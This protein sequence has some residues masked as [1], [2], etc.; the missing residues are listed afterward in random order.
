[1]TNDVNKIIRELQAIAADIEKGGD[2]VQFDVYG[3]CIAA[4]AVLKAQAEP[5][6]DDCGYKSYFDQ[7]KGVPDCNTCGAKNKCAYEPEPGALTRINCPLWART[8]VGE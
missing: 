8:E 1:M 6:C 2:T 7:Q 4:V 3:T 5:N